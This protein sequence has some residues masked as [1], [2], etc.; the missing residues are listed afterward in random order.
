[1]SKEH[2]LHPAFGGLSWRPSKGTFVLLLWVCFAAALVLE[3]WIG[4]GPD[5]ASQTPE[6]KSLKTITIR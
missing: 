1:M 6:D 2:E 4:L 5:W 3:D